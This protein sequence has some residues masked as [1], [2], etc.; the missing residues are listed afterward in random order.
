MPTFSG[1]VELFADDD[2]ESEGKNGD[3][4]G[5]QPSKNGKKVI[6]NEEILRGR[7]TIKS[8]E[9]FNRTRLFEDIQRL[10]DVY[11]D[12]GYAYANVT[13]NSS[14]RPDKKEVDLNL[15][16]ER[17]EIVYIDRIEVVGNTRTRD[18]VIRR[19]MRIY[20]GDKYT[21]S[22]INRS[23]ARIFQLGFFENVNITSSRGDEP[24]TM[25]LTVEVKEK[26]TPRPRAPILRGTWPWLST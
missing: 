14:L 18:K 9:R 2:G 3:G 16:I 26:S 23:R 20:E 11:R 15:E 13:P 4:S 17:G 24:N 8:G 19:E 1:E 5:G 25:N 10:T 6:V 22:G 12:Q 21:G 7:V